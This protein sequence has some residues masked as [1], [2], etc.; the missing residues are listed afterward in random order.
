MNRRTTLCW[1]L[2]V[3]VGFA[4]CDATTELEPNPAPA[5]FDLSPTYLLPGSTE[6]VVTLFGDGFVGGSRVRIGGFDRPSE[7]VNDTSL[8]VTL[9]SSDVASTGVLAV[10]VFNGG[11]GGGTSSS[12][13][14]VIGHPRPVVTGITPSVAM[15]GD[16][17]PSLRIRGT[18]FTFGSELVIGGVAVPS[19]RF[20]DTLLVNTETLPITAAAGRRSVVVNNPAPGGPSVS[21]VTFEVRNHRPRALTLESD[22]ALRGSPPGYVVV[23]GQHFVTGMLAF[24]GGL[25]RNVTRLSD[26]QLRIT[27]NSADVASLGTRPIY[28]TAPTPGGGASD[29]L[30]LRVVVPPPH[31][32][33]LSPATAAAGAAGLTL[34]IRGRD[35]VTGASVEWNGSPRTTT[36]VSDTLLT[37]ALT[38]GDLASEGTGS[39]LVRIPSR[40]TTSLVTG[41]PILAPSPSLEPGPL[42]VDLP[43]RAVI[44]DPVR[45]ALYA[46]IPSSASSYA[47]SL[48]KIDPLSGSVVDDIFLGSEPDALAISDDGSYLYVG[49]LGA[50]RVAR[51]QLSTFEH[52]GDLVLPSSSFG[53]ARPEDIVVIPGRPQTVAVSVRNTCCSPRH[54]GVV[55]FEGTTMLTRRTQGHTGSNRIVPGPDAQFMYGFNNETTEFGFRRIAVL[56]DGLVE[57]QVTSMFG[58][59]GSEITPAGGYV[60]TDG[61]AVISTYDFSLVGSLP[62]SGPVAPDPS[63][64]RIHVLQSEETLWTF[65]FSSLAYIGS[66]P[67][68]ASGLSVMT[69]WGTNG[70]AMGAGNR[71][72]IVRG[73]LIGP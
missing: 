59:F 63:A 17:V 57:T 42:V 6:R 37:I 53:T 31:I 10:T 28:V 16:T 21:A 43:N 24:V 14:F 12:V 38:T 50:Q 66:A 67:V 62:V 13:P 49:F 22:S 44:G 60:V 27:L 8:R 26:T 5:L 52:A 36:R 18:G 54:E 64:G 30:A 61:G 9:R 69:R 23:N 55:L 48:V 72:L 41:F 25:S 35:F 71:I 1:T 3:L 33:T 58:G 19:T 47:N 15:I 2:A 20:D 40:G 45:G 56:S 11:P 7:F 29:T 73:T 51:I 34:Q 65:S 70:L 39:V 4:A 68:N 32:T 46:S